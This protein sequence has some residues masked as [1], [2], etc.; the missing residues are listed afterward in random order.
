M[1]AGPCS[2]CGKPIWLCACH[3]TVSEVE[4]LRLR[5]G[6]VERDREEAKGEEERATLVRALRIAKDTIRAWHGIRL[7]SQEEPSVWE[8]YQGS[9]EMR[10]INAALGEPEIIS[11]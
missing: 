1:I 11:A 5:K 7:G 8:H 10:A 3:W 2:S 4:V 9:P 6:M